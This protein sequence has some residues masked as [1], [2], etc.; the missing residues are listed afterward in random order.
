MIGCVDI[1]MHGKG[2]GRSDRPTDRCGCYD[3]GVTKGY[4][5]GA[6]IA[7]RGDKV[8]GHGSSSS[9]RDAGG[10]AD[11]RRAGTCVSGG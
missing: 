6:G 7:G 1:D 4:A 2:T 8:I 3:F 10:K 11:V 5:G 9:C